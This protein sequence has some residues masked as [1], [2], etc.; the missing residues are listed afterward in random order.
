LYPQRI[1]FY[2][3]SGPEAARKLRD[4]GYSNMVVGV[5]GNALDTDVA[6]YIAAEAGIVLGK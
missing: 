6:E 2:S 1:Y 4:E 5:T 3:Q